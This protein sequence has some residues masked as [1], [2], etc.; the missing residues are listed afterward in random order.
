VRHHRGIQLVR[1]LG[2][3]VSRVRDD[4]VT[5][6]TTGLRNKL[7]GRDDI[8]MSAPAKARPVTLDT[9]GP[10]SWQTARWW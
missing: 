7:P 1:R 9:R 5:I 6:T 8:A 2:Y 3:P 10:P 4:Y